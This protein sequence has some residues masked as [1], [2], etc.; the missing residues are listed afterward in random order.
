M[1]STSD[2]GYGGQRLRLGFAVAQA[3]SSNLTVAVQLVPVSRSG[4]CQLPLMPGG[5]WPK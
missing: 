3:V 4:D 1:L 5:G 2:G